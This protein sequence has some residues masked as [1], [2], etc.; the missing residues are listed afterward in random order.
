VFEHIQLCRSKNT[1]GRLSRFSLIVS[2]IV[3]AVRLIC[4]LQLA[5]GSSLLESGL[6]LTL[7]SLDYCSGCLSAPPFF[8]PPNLFCI[9][10]PLPR[11]ASPSFDCR[12][13]VMG[14]R[15]GPASIGAMQSDVVLTP[16]PSL[17]S[18]TQL[19]VQ[20]GRRGQYAH[21][22]HVT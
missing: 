20:A 18:L 9:K 14:A 1:M 16:I 15:G 4:P 2:S 5:L 13:T 19:T 22:P 11:P 12:S 10:V 8:P 3:G 7:S 21:V 6:S 17:H